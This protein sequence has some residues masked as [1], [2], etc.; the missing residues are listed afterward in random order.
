[1]RG[2]EAA[3]SE[4]IVL[5]DVHEDSASE[6]VEG[7]V[8]AVWGAVVHSHTDNATMLGLAIGKTWPQSLAGGLRA[9]YASKAVEQLGILTAE[10]Q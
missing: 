4:A 3:T 5:K 2:T 7:E 8:V 10:T 6:A 9:F 1:M